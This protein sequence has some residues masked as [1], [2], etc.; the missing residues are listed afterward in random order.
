MSLTE[1]QTTRS[2]Q[3]FAR[4][5][6]VIPGGVNSPVR[7]F[8]AVGGQPRF[9]ARARGARV[10]DADDNEYL[11]YM[12]S[13]GPLPLGHSPPEV[14]AA[15]REAAEGGTSYGAPTEREVELAEEVSRAMPA[16]EMVRFV[17]SG[18]EAAMSGLR[19]A[20]A[21]SGRDVVVKLAGCYQGKSDALLVKD[22]SG[23]VS[24]G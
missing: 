18:T 21:F 15:I 6:Q 16:V 20:R 23:V 5:Q 17:S 13:W 22:G 8:K 1:Q 4:A 10:W 12:L 11:D 2:Q 7:A 9:F 24:L 14:V 3:L 19:V